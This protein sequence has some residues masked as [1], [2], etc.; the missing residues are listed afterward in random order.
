[1]RRSKHSFTLSA[2][3]RIGRG[4]LGVQV[5]QSGAREDVGAA[6]GLQ[7]R[8]GGYVLASLFGKFTLTPSWSVA[9][10]LDNAFG[11]RYGL[12]NGYVSA[13]RSASIST[14]YSFR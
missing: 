9:A 10:R 4:D 11:R 8:D 14:R 3:R 1:L 6:S 2:S 7:A 5:L 13:G 12:A